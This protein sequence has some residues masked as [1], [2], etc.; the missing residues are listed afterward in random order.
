MLTAIVA[1]SVF[2]TDTFLKIER[3]EDAPQRSHNSGYPKYFSSLRYEKYFGSSANVG[4]NCRLLFLR[5]G[6]AIMPPS[7]RQK[8]LI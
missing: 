5:N 7:W 2:E 1:F 4:Q 6:G 3:V 8:L